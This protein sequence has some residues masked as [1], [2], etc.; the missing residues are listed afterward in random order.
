MRQVFMETIE[1]K[2]NICASVHK[3]S[4]REIVHKTRVEKSSDTT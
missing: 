3:E 4:E 1:R 2:Q